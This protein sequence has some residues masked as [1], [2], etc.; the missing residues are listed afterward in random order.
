MPDGNCDTKV[1]SEELYYV[2]EWGIQKTES[3]W[4]F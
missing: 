3:M 2:F 4:K 1:E